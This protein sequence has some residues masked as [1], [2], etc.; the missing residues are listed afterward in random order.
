VWVPWTAS[1]TKRRTSRPISIGCG[2]G[3]RGSSDRVVKAERTAPRDRHIINTISR[4]EKLPCWR[5]RIS[6]LSSL[7]RNAPRAIMRGL[8]AR[9]RR[10]FTHAT[11]P[12]PQNIFQGH[13]LLS[14]PSFFFKIEICTV[15]YA[16]L[17]CPSRK[18]P[19][20]EM[21]VNDLEI[22]PRST[23]LV[24]AIVIGRLYLN[25]GSRSLLVG[26]KTQKTWVGL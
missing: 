25:S 17:S 16:H 2:P 22:R 9:E 15:T 1:L 6:P 18:C 24:F 12:N 3:R 26:E 5:P 23:S 11:R 4:C 19:M 10:T 13:P 8:A 21:E 7:V 20:W 14:R